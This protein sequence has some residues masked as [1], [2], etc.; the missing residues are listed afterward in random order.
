MKP[1]QKALEILSQIATNNNLQLFIQKAI[2]NS[3]G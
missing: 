3:D 2:A 1:A